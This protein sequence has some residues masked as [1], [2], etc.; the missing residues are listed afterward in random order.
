M[1]T[2]SILFISLSLNVVFLAAGAVQLT[3]NY[4]GGHKAVAAIPQPMQTPAEVKPAVD[5]PQRFQWSQLLAGDDESYAQNLRAIGCPE[6]TI[7]DIIT[8]AIARR[9]D[10]KRQ[11]IVTANKRGRMNVT[12]MQT[13]LAQ[14]WQ[15]QNQAINGGP[16]GTRAEA[17][18]TSAS[19]PAA[20][21]SLHSSDRAPVA[22]TA[23][24]VPSTIRA[25]SSGGIS[26]Y[27]NIHMPLA[28][29]DPP[30]SLGLSD[31]QKSAAAQVANT[32]TDAV[33]KSNLDPADPAYHQLWQDS[34]QSADDMLRAKIGQD[35]FV[36]WQ[37]QN[38]RSAA[39]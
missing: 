19:D 2:K 25:T 10:Q 16:E 23:T 6:S 35:A 12:T 36:K 8:A 32:F 34:Q 24:G 4:A 27:P 20:P 18:R 14:S 3:S 15:E 31:A 17:P 28:L 1:Q 33:A 22:A 9:F 30:E 11:E 26:G 5:S 38:R 7:R 13:A 39:N 37:L 21:T 29:S